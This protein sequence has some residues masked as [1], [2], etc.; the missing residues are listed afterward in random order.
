[1]PTAAPTADK[2]KGAAGGCSGDGG[3][4]CTPNH[5]TVCKQGEVCCAQGSF[6]SG[7]LCILAGVEDCWTGSQCPPTSPYCLMSCRTRTNKC[8]EVMPDH[9]R[10]I[11]GSIDDS[12]EVCCTNPDFSNPVL[13]PD[14]EPSCCATE[15]PYPF[16]DCESQAR[17]CCPGPTGN[18]RRC[19]GTVDDACYACCS[20]PDYS[21]EVIYPEGNTSCCPETHPW[22]CVQNGA[23]SCCED[24]GQCGP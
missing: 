19:D 10:R 20:G 22:P 9:P 2:R 4:E 3:E 11:D 21:V 16:L 18:P 13:W 15:A 12:C 7:Y 1:M 6:C 17:M 24:P 23:S 14:G 5:H 8:C